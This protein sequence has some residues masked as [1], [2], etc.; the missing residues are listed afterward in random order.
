MTS[1][2]PILVRSPADLLVAVPYLLGF[3]PIESVV[4]VVFNDR[5]IIFAARGDLPPA[6]TSPAE[7]V[8]FVAAVVADQEASGAAV[9][10]YG[11]SERVDPVLSGLRE[12]LA[13]RGVPVLEALRAAGGYYWSQLC[14]NAACCPPEGTAYDA[15]TSPVA[16][17]ATYA[18]HTALPDRDAVARLVAPVGGPV[19]ES[20]RQATQLAEARHRETF[21]AGA[22]NDRQGGRALLLAGEAA[23]AEAYARG[24]AGEPLADDE[25]AWLSILLLHTPVRDLAWRLITGEDWQVRLWADVVR[26]VESDVT[27]APASL[28]A[29]AAWR[30]GQGA[31]ANIA[32]D[33]ALDE[34]PG[35]PMALLV[36]RALQEALSPEV[37][38][39]SWPPGSGGEP[40]RAGVDVHPASAQEGDERHTDLLGQVHRQRARCRHGGQHG[41]AGHRR[42]LRE[43]EAGPPG[44]QQHM[45][46]QR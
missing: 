28:L 37:L 23:V 14:D 33:R 42:L 32:V 30:A 46:P 39:L 26:R 4:V 40:G 41:N 45:P 6:A 21:Q 25:V 12:A 19:R 8:R 43:L 20:M 36:Q 29:F 5:Q 31:L 24:A 27:P 2:P 1:T 16:A 10:G 17:A 44:D 35:Y 3:H 9:I 38:D 18:G 22:V 13:A 11:T 7:M 34:D 15:A